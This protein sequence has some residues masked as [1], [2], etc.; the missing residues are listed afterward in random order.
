MGLVGHRI[1]AGQPA[2]SLPELLGAGVDV[3]IEPVLALLQLLLLPSG[4][5]DGLGYLRLLGLRLGLLGFQRRLPLPRADDGLA[6]G[7]DLLLVLGDR[8]LEGLPEGFLLLHVLLRLLDGVLLRR[9]DDPRILDLL[10]ELLVL[11]TDLGGDLLLLGG[12]LHGLGVACLHELRLDAVAVLYRLLGL[13]D[14]FRIGLLLRGLHLEPAVRVL[15]LRLVQGVL[16]VQVGLGVEPVLVQ[17]P[18]LVGQLLHDD[19]D[20][21]EIG[22]GLG[23]LDPGLVY[24]GV[25]AR[26][27]GDPVDDPA[28][29]QIPHLDDAGDVPLLHEIVSVRGDARLGEQRIELGHGGLAV[30]DVEVRAVIGAVVGQLDVTGEADDVVVPGHET[31]GVVEDQGHL[32]EPRL[33]LGLAAVEDEVG[34]LPRADRLGTLGSEDEKDRIG[35]V[36]FPGSVGTRDRRVPLHQRN[37]DLPAEGFEI[38]H[39]DR[40]QMHLYYTP[41]GLGPSHRSFASHIALV[42]SERGPFITPHA[43]ATKGVRAVRI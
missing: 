39:L 14:L 33:R 32:G 6:E 15:R 5:G 2:L 29:L 9:Q 24:V 17:L 25:E 23:P 22:L 1:G 41:S 42:R 30:V 11:G 21:L 10:L 18:D 8:A 35:D 4:L 31:V 26:D 7:V 40:F 28:P 34:E 16:R 27:P 13:P 19:A 43:H 38:L 37:G 12:D 36:R 3:G 20:P